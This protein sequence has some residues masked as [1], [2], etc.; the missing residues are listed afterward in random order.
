[1][2]CGSS[3]NKGETDDKEAEDTLSN[4]L[5]NKGTLDEL[6]KKFDADGNEHIDATEFNN[7]IFHSLLFFCKQRNPDLPPPSQENMAPFIEKLTKQLQPFVD[8]DQDMKIT[9]E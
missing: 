5:N 2:G 4:F 6:F 8:K 9:K 1:M 7:L 3:K